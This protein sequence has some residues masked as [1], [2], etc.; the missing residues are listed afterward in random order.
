[1]H[2]FMQRLD[3]NDR[4]LLVGDSRQHEAVDAGRPFAQLQ[5]AGMRTAKLDE[6]VRQRDP[7]LRRRSSSW[8]AVRWEPQLRVL[9]SR[10]ACMK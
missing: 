4:V 10:T 2:E 9:T 8:H 3:R 6:I 5:E 7:E 1:M